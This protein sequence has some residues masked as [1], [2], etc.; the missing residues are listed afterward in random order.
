[1]DELN[2]FHRK[3]EPFFIEFDGNY[4]HGDIISDDISLPPELLCLH[5]D[6]A[7]GRSGFLL[8][9]QLLLKKHAISSCAFDF[10]GF[11]GS[12][13]MPAHSG[14]HWQTQVTQATDIIDACFDSQPL[15]IVAS[16]CSAQAALHLA[17]TFPV[18]QVVL[19]NP[20]PNWEGIGNF[21][22]QSVAMPVAGA[23]TLS[24]LNSEPALLLK[25][26]KLI[27]DTLLGDGHLIRHSY[28]E[29][30]F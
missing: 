18:R 23:K 24:Y 26:A 19:L 17:T 1:M 9:R 12:T 5:G 3:V 10:S 22:W 20:P 13:N 7:E 25:I 21:S 28:K 27:K 15:S 2:T 4:L 16:D 6:T 8:L 14:L 11:G 29:Y 30:S